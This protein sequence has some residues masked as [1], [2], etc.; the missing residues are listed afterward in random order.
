MALRPYTD[1]IPRNIA[2]YTPTNWPNVTAAPSNPSTPRQLWRDNGV[3]W[4]SQGTGKWWE[5]AQPLDQLAPRTYTVFVFNTDGTPSLTPIDS[6]EFLATYSSKSAVETYREFRFRFP[7]GVP[8]TKQIT[9]PASQAGEL[10]FGGTLPATPYPVT[11]PTDHVFFVENGLIVGQ[12]YQEFIRA[13]QPPPMGD[14]QKYAVMGSIFARTDL[15]IP[16]KLGM[17]RQLL[18]DRPTPV[19]I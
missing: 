1:F 11:V 3:V 5:V 14:D 6:A 18:M 8:Y 9:V 12:D 15:S 2:W 16:Q 10:N 13:N 17:F 19:L 4:E 7:S